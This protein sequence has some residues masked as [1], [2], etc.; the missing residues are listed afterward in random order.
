M[1]DLRLGLAL[2]CVIGLASAG[3]GAVENLA[4]NPGFE[5]SAN[6]QPKGYRSAMVKGRLAFRVA[7]DPVRGKC[8]QIRSTDTEAV[9]S[10][11]TSSPVAVA[12]GSTVEV[13]V[14]VKLDGVDPGHSGSGAMFAFHFYRD[15]RYVSWAS[16]G[17]RVGTQAWAD[18]AYTVRVPAQAD[19]MNVSMRLSQATGTVWLDDLRV[20]GER[21]KPAERG[22]RQ[23]VARPVG[24]IALLQ[25]RSHKDYDTVI[26]HFEHERFA[27]DHYHRGNIATFPADA[28]SLRRYTAVVYSSLAVEGGVKLLSIEQ[29]RALV[30]Y[31]RAGGGF[32]TVVGEL[33]GT[34]LDML[35]PIHVQASVRACHFI[36]VVGEASHPIL[37]GIPTSWPGFGTKYNAY[38]KA[39]LRPGAQVLMTVPEKVSPPGTPFLAVMPF[40]EGRVVCM[41]SLWCYGT[42]SE[43]KW[44]RYA[45]RFFGQAA[46]WAGRL[47]ALSDG[48][49]IP[50]PDWAHVDGGGSYW[51]MGADL[52]GLPESL[53]AQLRAM[54][55]APAAKV[56]LAIDPLEPRPARAVTVSAAAVVTDAG[57]HLDIRLGNGVRIRFT[58]S[59]SI[60]VETPS[61][62]RVTATGESKPPLI[63]QSGTDPL[64]LLQ[65]VDA[66]TLTVQAPVPKRRRLDRAFHYASHRCDGAAVV[67][68]CRIETVDKATAQ[69]DWAFLP[70]TIEIN[71][72]RWQGFGQ[73]FTLRD[74]KHF[75]E[76]FMDQTAWRMGPTLS[77]HHTIRTACYSQPRGVHEV[78]FKTGQKGHSGKWSYC[79]GGQPFQ[80]VGSD[81]GTLF[82]YMETPTTVM[83][84]TETTPKATALH[85]NHQ[86][87]VGRQRGMVTTPVV[88]RLWGEQPLTP[89]LWMELYGHVRDSYCQRW[90][91]RRAEPVPSAMSRFDSVAQTGYIGVTAFI[92]P[93]T[94]Q[95]MAD[96]FVPCA[97]RAGMKRIDVGHVIGHEIS[98]EA[99]KRNGGAEGLK[100]LVDKCHSLGME[101]YWYLRIAIYNE[102]LQLFHAHPDWLVKNKD[103]S[104]YHG[105]FPG[106][107][108]C[109]MK[110]EWF[111]Y[112]LKLYR[113][114]KRDYAMDGVWFD[115]V[116]FAFDPFNYAEP[117]PSSMA[118]YGIRY[119]KAFQNLGYQYWVEGQNALGL[120]SFWYRKSK[121]TGGYEGREFALYDTSPWT[122]GPDGA[123]FLD[124]FKLASY[125]CC[126]VIDVRLMLDPESALTRR[127][128]ECSRKFNRAVELVGHPCGIKQTEFG[129][130]WMAERGWALFAHEPRVVTVKGLPRLKSME[131][132]G[133]GSVR[134]EGGVV[135]ADLWGEDVAVLCRE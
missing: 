21:G 61:G 71:G 16:S 30:E 120:D 41:N 102:N 116:G 4:P 34:A 134:Q 114:W 93:F 78:R 11:V 107:A 88:W 110:S 113:Q 104:N 2:A 99:F 7:T 10:W 51:T 69:L 12:P 8:L 129:T 97:A 119:L 62:L 75:V 98:P 18:L 77:G 132:V 46:R 5:L 91:I 130:L 9:G 131:V 58:K 52:A 122:M 135:V 79:S 50:P 82:T 39:A 111:D 72:R 73:A 80:V 13:A 25:Q 66:E 121:Y 35:L 87:R 37:A 83:A 76:S 68:R 106:M 81:R 85:V 123:F 23:S 6:G 84:W 32:C 38:S 118:P 14:A 57:E 112:S 94:Y 24:R 20:M 124:L 125:H 26:G 100:Y 127:I 22:P 89:T 15:G 36:P 1:N 109:S 28:R 29:C 47:P 70:R 31:V 67:V 45:P 117:E 19:T 48:D 65:N 126:P 90:G 3:S 103:G 43:M 105:A 54:P 60:D 59:C 40:G 64:P 96:V 56:D 108:V 86:I 95:R 128:A 74:E 92:E 133:R 42:G 33:P 63:A 53:Q 27:V 49:R 17:G 115:T 44:W 55:A 101:A